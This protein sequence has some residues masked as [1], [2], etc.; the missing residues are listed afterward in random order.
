MRIGGETMFAYKITGDT[1]T[2]CV[3]TGN[4][5]KLNELKAAGWFLSETPVVWSKQRLN[6]GVLEDIPAPVVEPVPEP[7]VEELRQRRFA[8]INFDYQTKLRKMRE[9]LDMLEAQSMPTDKVKA[10]YTATV[11]EYKAALIEAS[12]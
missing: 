7:T 1:S 11:A 5:E 4:K 8:E 6:N 2:N 3:S 10:Q 12:K 9:T